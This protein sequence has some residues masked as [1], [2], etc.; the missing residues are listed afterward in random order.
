MQELLNDPTFVRGIMIAHVLVTLYLTIQ[1]YGGTRIRMSEHQAVLAKETEELQKSVFWLEKQ[2][3]NRVTDY[4]GTLAELIVLRKRVAELEGQLLAVDTT[5]LDV[6]EGTPENNLRL[7]RN[8]VR[9][10]NG[11]LS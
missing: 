1:A 2:L 4:S 3:D 5:L 11:R 9:T 8:L 10:R 6:E 7:L